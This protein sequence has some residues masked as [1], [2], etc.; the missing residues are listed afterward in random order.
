MALLPAASSVCQT[1]DGLRASFDA[2]WNIWGPVGGYVA[3]IA[4]RAVGAVAPAGHRPVTLS[5]LF[6][7]RGDNGPVDI[8]VDPIKAGSTAFWSVALTQSGK[9]VLRAQMCTTTKVEGPEKIDCVAPDVRTPDEL[10]PFVD[11]LRRFGHEPIPYLGCQSSISVSSGS[12]TQMNRP[13]GFESSRFRTAT[14]FWA[15]RAM[16]ASMLSTEKLTMNSR[17]EGFI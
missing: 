9:T 14:P 1:E 3:A 8:K 6:V 12:I 4:L 5:C 15:N 2:E 10:E 11:Q 13:N 16:M 17:L 7:S